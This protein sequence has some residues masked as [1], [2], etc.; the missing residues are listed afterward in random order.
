MTFLVGAALSFPG[1]TYLNTLDHLVKLN[2]GVL[3]SILL[4]V[5]F[6]MMQQLLIELPLVSMFGL[7]ALGALLL[8]R[9]VIAF[10]G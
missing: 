6:C 4:V 8:V 5:F 1:V 7:A 2:P 10:A 3:F 9:G